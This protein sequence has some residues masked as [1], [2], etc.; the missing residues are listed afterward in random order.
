MRD[1]NQDGIDKNGVGTG[2]CRS[3]SKGPKIKRE[4]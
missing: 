3:P 1:V 2:G 4:I